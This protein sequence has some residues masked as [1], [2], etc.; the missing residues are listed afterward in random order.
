MEVSG[1]SLAKISA[2]MWRMRFEISIS[3][4]TLIANSY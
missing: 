3:K 4:Y 1:F 2:S